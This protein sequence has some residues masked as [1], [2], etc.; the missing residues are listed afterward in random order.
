MSNTFKVP[1]ICCCFSHNQSESLINKKNKYDI[2][3]VSFTTPDTDARTINFVNTLIKNNKKV[4]LI[5]LQGRKTYA[6]YGFDLI[7]IPDKVQSRVFIR[8][9]KFTKSITRLMDTIEA[10]I[11]VA[12]DLFSLPAANKLSSKKNSK[13]IYD[14]REVYS[15]LGPI[16]GQ[17]FKQKILTF[18]EKRYVK[19]VSE[20]IISG[21]LDEDVLSRHFKTDLPFHLVMNLPPFKEHIQS[22]LIRETFSIENDNYIILYQGAILPGRGLDIAI[23]AMKFIDNANLCII[24]DG[25]YFKKIKQDVIDF[26]LSHKVHFTGEIEYSNLHKWTCSADI[27]LS[28]FEKVSIS[29]ELALPNKLFEY[30]MANIPSIASDLPAMREVIEEN[31]IGEL[32]NLDSG[33]ELLAGEI[34]KI[35]MPEAREGYIKACKKASEKFCYESQEQ[36]IISIFSGK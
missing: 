36:K 20:F 4:C 33:P 6:A 14:S 5:A 32:F 27:G 30:C 25:P 12:E 26:N 9:Y 2:C 24:G 18:I 23:G 7:S 13:L 28:L 35:L 10:D 19:G 34:Q 1:E 21:K 15:A 29:Y 3:V 11:F 17:N 22:N 16:H 8:W 31:K